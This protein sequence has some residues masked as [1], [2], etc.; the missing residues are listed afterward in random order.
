V[1]AIPPTGAPVPDPRAQLRT[2]ARSLEGVFLAQMFQA[3]RAAV[4]QGEA[5]T[6][7]GQD[8]VTALLDERLAELAAQRLRG[9][10]GDALYRQ[11]SRRL[12]A[13]GTPEPG[14]PHGTP[15]PSAPAAGG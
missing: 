13:T 6:A 7:P 5:P 4:P 1:T 2:L 3:M 8:L 15:P 11:L 10:M 14:H 9:G 12:D